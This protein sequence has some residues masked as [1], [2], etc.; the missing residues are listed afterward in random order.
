MYQRF[1]HNRKKVL[2]TGIIV[3]AAAFSVCLTLMLLQLK[4]EDRDNFKLGLTA[5]GTGLSV[6]LFFGL[7][8]LGCVSEP[9]D[10]SIPNVAGGGA[11]PHH[12][13]IRCCR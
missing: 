6:A 10:N 13:L 7:A 4:S 8:I 12:C 11:D 9:D 3:G 5:T 1:L 2:A